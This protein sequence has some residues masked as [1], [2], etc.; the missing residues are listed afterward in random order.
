MININRRQHERH[1]RNLIPISLSAWEQLA[2][3]HLRSGVVGAAQPCGL[4][5]LSLFRRI[6]RIGE[7][8]FGHKLQAKL[9][10]DSLP[11]WLGKEELFVEVAVCMK[12][13]K[14]RG[15]NVPYTGSTRGTTTYISIPFSVVL[16]FLFLLLLIHFPHTILRHYRSF[17]LSLLASLSMDKR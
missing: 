1:R 12:A 10:W 7:R 3:L 6:D 15:S 9:A 17:F 5:L 13:W 8:W 2:S 4:W 11:G 14:G 16:S